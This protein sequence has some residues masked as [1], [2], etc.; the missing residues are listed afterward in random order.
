M[1]FISKKLVVLLLLFSYLTSFRYLNDMDEVDYSEYYPIVNELKWTYEISENGD[2]YFQ[3]VFMK[4]G[5]NV[6]DNSF[7]IETEGK[8]KSVL[9][10]SVAQGI[11]YL[12]NIQ[13]DWGPIPFLLPITCSSPIPVFS[14]E[15][16]RKRRW[17][18][19]GSVGYSFI[20]KDLEITY[21]YMGIEEINIL[22]LK[23]TCLKIVTSYKEESSNKTIT[24][25]FAKGIGLVRETSLNY[26]K[27]IIKYE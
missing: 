15:A 1:K 10:Y 12:T 20:R 14:L 17:N 5:V 24:S 11:V 27:K 13:I 26:E 23:Y 3:E 18:W 16:N 8:R 6:K 19:N 7:L 9:E 22:N 21:E 25:W 4:Q 2:K